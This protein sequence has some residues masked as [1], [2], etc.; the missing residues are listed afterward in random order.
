MNGV[1]LV[2]DDQADTRAM[3]AAHLERRGFTVVEAIDGPAALEIAA[4]RRPDVIV[5][6]VDMPGLDGFEV[7]DRL[8]RDPTLAAVPVIVVTGS[9]TTEEVAAALERGAHDWLRKPVHA[10][11]LVARVAGA[12]RMKQLQDSLDAEMR[13]DLTTGLPNRRHL[14]EHLAMLAS[15]ARRQRTPLALLAVDV[16]GA[17]ALATEL[18][19]PGFDALVRAVATRIVNSLRAEDVA[20]RWSVSRILVACPNTGADGAWTV[21]DRIRAAVATSPVEAGGTD[22]VVTVSVGCA[23][24]VGDDIDGLRRAAEQAAAEAATTGRNRVVVAT[25]L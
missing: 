9:L 14:E 16:D 18:D 23:E 22:V 3:T 6:D 13:T 20:G 1:V 7:L 12:A 17:A 19:D 4:A 11:E 15:A 2:A 25:R 5:L 21:A 8:Q 10:A 24:G